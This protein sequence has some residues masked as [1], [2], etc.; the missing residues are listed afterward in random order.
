LFHNSKLK[1][2]FTQAAGQGSS[3]G[4]ISN[5][6]SEGPLSKDINSLVDRD[7]SNRMDQQG[8]HPGGSGGIHE[9]VKNSKEQIIKYM[10][11]SKLNAN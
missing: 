10:Q 3:S 5:E 4:E 1:K 6:K 8:P 9:V 7:V 2:I 11:R